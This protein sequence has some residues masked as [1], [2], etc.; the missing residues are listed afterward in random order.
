IRS[1]WT[2]KNGHVNWEITVP[3]NS[4]ANVYIPYGI[5]RTITEG[6]KRIWVNGSALGKIS[7]TKLKGIETDANS[8][9]QYIV[10]TVGSGNYEFHW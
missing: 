10:W 1:S 9:R 7:G 8:G 5:D 6:G 4:K 3:V 2:N